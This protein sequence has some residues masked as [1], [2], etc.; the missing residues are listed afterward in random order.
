MTADYKG[1][2]SKTDCSV[3]T[4]TA[5]FGSMEAPEKEAPQQQ[6]TVDQQKEALDLKQ[7]LFIGATVLV[8]AAGGAF[9]FKKYRERR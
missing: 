5:V 2:V 3:L 9:L 8:L 4:Y 6:E 7:P 1:Q